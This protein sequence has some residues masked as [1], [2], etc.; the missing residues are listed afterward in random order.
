MSAN[1]AEILSQSEKL[2]QDKQ[3]WNSQFQLVS[4][5]VG[6]RKADFTTQTEPGA[7]LN[8]E[9]WSDLAPLSAETAASA[10][11]GL[12]WPDSYSF[13]LE[14][15]GDLKDDEE[16]KQWFEESTNELQSAMDDPEAGLSLAIDEAFNDF[17]IYGT[18]ALHLE[19]GDTTDLRF[20]AWNV[21]QFALDEDASG[22]VD[23]FHRS[24]KYTVRQ[25]VKKFGIDKVSKKTRDAYNKKDYLQKVCVL[26]VIEPRTVNP[27]GGT[28]SHNMP[29]ASIYIE[30]DAKHLIKESGFQ[31]LPTFAFRYSKRIG[32]K[33]GR[34]PS[35]RALPTIMELN[36]LWELVTTGAEKNYDPPLAVY[37][38]GTFGGGT[39]DTSAGAI[40]VINVS[41]KATSNRPPIEPL[42]TVGNFQDLAVLIE[43]LE[44]TVKDHYMI[45]RL[46]D[47]NNETEMTARE[48]I[49]RQA[50]RQAALRSV[51]SR[52]IAE[53]FNR[54]I[55]RAFNIL[56]RKGRFGYA[57]GSPEYIAA[58]ALDPEAKKIPQKIVD[59]QGKNQRVY[60]IRYKTPAAREQ[61]AQIAQGILNM[62]E[63][64][65]SVAAF[66]STVSDLVNNERALKKLGDIWS[67]PLE[68]WNDE[69][70]L[71]AVRAAKAGAQKQ[72]VDL[73]N[74]AQVAEIAKTAA[75]AR[76]EAVL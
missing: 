46:L 48:A 62:Y 45:D 56:L 60:T 43:R 5:Y 72:Q 52:V 38:D 68:F 22:Y 59:A 7:F 20:D 49:I 35:M 40:N 2:N 33:Y 53:L 28:G 51:V 58:S 63:T 31:E 34:S 9:I 65:G 29:Y 14:P 73:A 30:V 15:F 27:K 61:E 32:E 23:T 66:D 16:C 64:L 13:D 42:F 47:L 76:P 1:V 6:Q 17:T 37:D 54:M 21:S 41:A 74:A 44:Q 39:I 71:Q 69:D 24:R 12:L 18:P 50:L 55:P 10:L 3:P 75:A 4:E 36:A 67:V 70:E 19:E 26:H 57:E 25:M 8:S 11:V